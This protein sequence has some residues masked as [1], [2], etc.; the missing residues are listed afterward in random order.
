MILLQETVKTI[1]MEVTDTFEGNVSYKLE[2]YTVPDNKFSI[3]LYK[4]RT[5]RVIPSM[6]EQAYLADEA[7]WID[8]SQLLPENIRFSS[9]DESIAAAKSALLEYYRI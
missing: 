5:F 2:I 1:L 9:I 4:K 8:A 7:F 3:N 6:E